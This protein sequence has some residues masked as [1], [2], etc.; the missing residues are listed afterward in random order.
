MRPSDHAV[1]GDPD[2][3]RQLDRIKPPHPDDPLGIDAIRMLLGRL[4]DPQ[5]AIPPAFHIA[6]TNGKGSTCAFLR[7]MLEA[8]GYRVHSYSSPHLVRVNERIRVRGSLIGDG[9]LAQLLGEVLDASE[10]LGISF[11]EVMTAA[12]FLAFAREP[13]DAAIIEVGLGG[14]LDATNVM[15]TPVA[16]GIAQLALDHQFFLGND[17]CSIAAEKAGI[18]KAGVPLVTMDY[19]G[20]V[21]D[22]VGRTAR[23]AGA[24]WLP[25]AKSWSSQVKGGVAYRDDLGSLDLPMPS[26]AGVHQAENAALAVAMLRHQSRLPVAEHAL[27]AGITTAT[28]PARL[29]PLGSGPFTTRVR[30]VEGEIWLDGGHNPS[31]GDM[32]RRH[33]FEGGMRPHS[34]TVILAMLAGKD[35]QGFIAAVAPLIAHLHAVPLAGQQCHPSDYLAKLAAIEGVPATAHSSLDAAISA[36]GSEDRR[37]GAMLIAGSLHLAGEILQ[38]NQQAAA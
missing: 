1:S 36:L 33:F 21:A 19:P 4:G 37:P 26:L 20:S 31:A 23:S 13:A 18:A 22:V 6:G 8:A 27:C 35:A 14:R 7:A 11:F 30:A 29:Q 2:V 10:G 28:W 16:T 24:V 9:L 34:L 25:R 5:Y 32:L 3:Q 15:R 12:A 38:L 17:L